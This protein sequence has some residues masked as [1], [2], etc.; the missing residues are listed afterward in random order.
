MKRRSFLLA[1]AVAMT[2]GTS[3]RAAFLDVPVPVNAYITVG[4]LDWAWAAPLPGPDNGLDLSYQSQFGWHIPTA[5]ELTMAPLGTQFL[6]AGANVPFNGTD[7]VSGAFFSATNAA[8]AAAGSAGAVA[9]PYFDTVYHHAD[10]Q[11]GLGQPNGPWAGMT[12]ANS[13]ADQLV[14]RNTP[15]ATPEPSS[16]TVVGICAVS[17]A[18]YGYRRR[19]ARSAS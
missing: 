9:T 15:T 7:P 5:Q 19:L 4:G 10:W 8:Y 2:M 14:V 1:L 3:A 18:A 17:L 12:G 6:F 13:L 16:L 11:D